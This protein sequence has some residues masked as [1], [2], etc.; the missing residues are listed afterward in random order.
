MDQEPPP[1]EQRITG[2]RDVPRPEKNQSSQ[3]QANFNDSSGP[4]FDMY[5]KM[6][7]KEDEKMAKRWQKDADGILI[8][9]GLFSAAL[10]AL[11]A[12]SVQDLKPNPQDT[13]AFY[14]ANIYQLLA[15]PNI[16]R[17]SILATTAQPPPFS[18]PKSAVFVNSLWFLSLVI[19][20]TC[21]LLATMLQQWARRYVTITQ[22][23]RYS[24]HRRAP[25]R[26]F[27]ANGVEKFHLP[28]SVEALPALLHL[29]LFLFFSGL[30]IFLFNINH[31]V[32]SVVIWWVGLAGAV[33]GCVTLMPIFWNDSPYYAPLS[34]SMWFFYSGI[35]YAV[36]RITLFL[37]YR[38]TLFAYTS[39]ARYRTRF[40]GGMTKAVQ[41][42]GEKLSA[43]IND[44]ILTWTLDSLDEDKDFEQLIEAIPGFCSSE[45]VRD[46]VRN[47]TP[48]LAFTKVDETLAWAFYGFI[49]RTLASSSV[50]EADKKRRIIISAK[51]ADTAQLARTTMYTLVALFLFDD[52]V[53]R[54][55]EIVR[56]L[57]SSDDGD[58]GLCSQGIISGVIA[59]VPERDDRWIALAKGQLGVSDEVLRYYLANGDS[60]LLANLIHITR[61]LVHLCFSS[62][63]IPGGDLRTVLECISIFDIENTLPELQH[64]FCSLWNE[65]VREA[66]IRESSTIS[67]YILG[68][69]RHLYIALHQ[70]TDA[71]S[72]GE[73]DPFKYQLC[74]IPGH[75]SD[76]VIGD[77][78]PTS[79]PAAD[80]AP[81]INPVLSSFPAL[82]ADHR[83]IDIA[84][85][86]SPHDVPDATDTNNVDLS[87]ISDISLS[88]LP[89]SVPNDTVAANTL[90]SL[91]FQIN[92][93]TA[94]PDP[95]PLLSTSATAILPA[96]PEG[97][98]VLHPATAL[99]DGTFNDRRDPDLRHNVVGLEQSQKPATS[100]PE[101][102]TDVLRHPLDEASVSRDI[103]HSE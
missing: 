3:G 32:F 82:N 65:I 98:P 54:S 38:Y 26:A 68:A 91:A 59:N 28:W 47:S 79:S 93:V 86:S 49:R 5:V 24:P 94:P 73:M 85:Q 50:S 23:P 25:I 33:Y 72:I 30:G 81:S 48:Q 100:A 6:T 53:L 34:S 89:A 29:A 8:F 83:R 18:P 11:A 64:D 90:A 101:V 2:L 62:N 35:Q 15:N 84:E 37:W 63:S 96:L 76:T 41:D 70:D 39:P 56:S 60:V 22:P 95:L 74:D 31:T 99:N 1:E 40:L 42:T 44:R 36:S 27:F 13:S 71:A 88:P 77:R 67:F 102:A 58:P 4:L 19:S 16:S 51:A 66:H 80:I 9:T 52:I 57:R 78:N 61:P 12:V 14:L 55:D 17:E 75:H 97:T 20:L 69:I 46:S 7:E 43:E 92:Q 21:A 87:L 10:A 45:V 103:D